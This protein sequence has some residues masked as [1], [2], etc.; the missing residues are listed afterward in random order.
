[1]AADQ[2][3]MQNPKFQ[4]TI[5]HE[6]SNDIRTNLQFTKVKATG[7]SFKHACNLRKLK[8]LAT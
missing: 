6:A 8:R 5:R 4:Q 7:N 1:M 2:R 3:S